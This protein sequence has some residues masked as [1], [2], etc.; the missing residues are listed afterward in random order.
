MN[1]FGVRRDGP[2]LSTPSNFQKSP[3]ALPGT[4]ILETQNLKW[5]P[6]RELLPL[7]DTQSCQLCTSVLS[8]GYESPLLLPKVTF[9]VCLFI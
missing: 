2:V 8:Q 3:T 7:C 4:G 6:P 1:D 9:P 5:C